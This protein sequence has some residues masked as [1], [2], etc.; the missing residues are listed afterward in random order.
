M[1]QK[2]VLFNTFLLSALLIFLLPSISWAKGK[3]ET[4]KVETRTVVAPAIPWTPT[5]V[6]AIEP[7]RFIPKVNGRNGAIGAATAV[8]SAAGLKCL[9]DG[10]NAFDAAVVTAAMITVSEFYA[11]GIGGHG[12]MMLYVAETDEVKCLDFG[13]GLP[14]KW[15]V[16]QL[17][18]PTTAP[19][20]TS[21]LT[22]IQPGTLAGWAELLDKHGTISLAEALAPAIKYAEE[23][24]PVN[25][26]AAS[27]I[28]G[29]QDMISLLPEAAKIWMPNGRPP[30]EGEMIVFKDLAET[31][32]RIGKEG[33][34]LFYKGELA[35]KIVKYLN[36]NGQRFTKEEFANYKPIWQELLSNTYRD[37]YE[38]FVVK[39]QNY[40]PIILTMLN[41]WENFD[42][43]G[44]GLYSVED[45]HLVIEAMKVALADRTTY[46][47]DPA[48]NDVPYDILI[49]KEY[50]KSIVDRIDMR[51]A[52]PSEPGNVADFAMAD[53]RYGD[54]AYFAMEND[55][56][57]DKETTSNLAVVD[58]DHNMCVITQ[59]L[60]AYLG[61]LHIVPGTG[62]T[63]NSEGEY[64]DMFPINGSNYPEPGKKPE[65]QMGPA[66]VKKNGKIFLGMGSPGGTMIPQAIGL[67]IQRIIDHGFP[68]QDAIE[69]PRIRY[70][71]NGW[72]EIERGIPWPVL[73]KLWQMDHK[74]KTPGFLAGL[75]GVLID[76]E[77]GVM[78]AGAEPM[79]NYARVAY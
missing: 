62:I 46:Y 22:T 24:V 69:L 71:E 73:E 51:R 6:R 1:K 5:T 13:G 54:I 20:P 44:L 15:S 55:R 60:G 78:E 8:A 64:F 25:S 35:D 43:K 12:T 63:L 57:G 28:A 4:Q 68:I 32:R 14:K 33:P 18:S 36:D 31:Y 29:K 53:D 41:I 40:T 66:I 17:D 77:T 48:F 37:E 65:N 30:K 74:I 58:K 47:G 38:V 27:A 34:D 10:G 11:S 21:V 26:S 7:P 42:M 49:S 75:S 79:R 72:T 2:H 67:A 52:S 76:P 9:Q 19:E 3:T 39:N 61:N 70:R 59:T 56:Y 50:A 16:D 45:I 23:G